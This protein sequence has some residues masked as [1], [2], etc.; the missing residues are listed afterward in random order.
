M[1]LRN[2]KTCE[3]FMG[4]GWNL[5]AKSLEEFNTHIWKFDPG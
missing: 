4:Y 5:V 1:D 2:G 3:V